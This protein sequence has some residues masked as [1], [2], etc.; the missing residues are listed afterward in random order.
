MNEEERA[1][2]DTIVAD[3]A[4]SA[5]SREI[6]TQAVLGH[7]DADDQA[8]ANLAINAVAN[9]GACLADA[10]LAERRK[11]VPLSDAGAE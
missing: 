2:W 7:P 8:A 4:N 6:F 1:L 10:V 3:Y 11:R 5:H 9:F